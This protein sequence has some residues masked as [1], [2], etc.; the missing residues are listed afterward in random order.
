M[1]IKHSQGINIMKN[2]ILIYLL[3]TISSFNGFSQRHFF[4][5]NK[6]LLN[7]DSLTIHFEDKDSL[8][9]KE[10]IF[11][12]VGNDSIKINGNY[13]Y[14]FTFSTS[15]P[16]D[17]IGYIR[18]NCDKIFIIPSNKS[19]QKKEQLLFRFSKAKSGWKLSNINEL[20]GSTI[21]LISKYYSSIY[22]ENIFVFILKFGHYPT[23]TLLHEIHI[24]LHTGLIKA[25]FITH[26]GSLK[27]ECSKKESD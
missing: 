21:S 13:Y 15:H 18:H 25:V 20:T 2:T 3:L 11:W 26:Y 10:N 23:S 14:P 24:G 4:I 27:L 17:T 5:E 8:T 22:K 7:C 16:N 9:I 1:I 6:I 19:F 12:E